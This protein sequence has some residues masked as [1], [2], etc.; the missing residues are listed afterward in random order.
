MKFSKKI[1]AQT[2]A[3]FCAALTLAFLSGPLIGARAVVITEDK[4]VSEARQ[5]AFELKAARET[6][7]EASGRVY[8]GFSGFLPKVTLA[9]NYTKLSAPQINISG[10]AA[11]LFAGNF[12][13]AMTATDLYTGQLNVSQPLFAWGRIYHADRQARLGYKMA[14]EKYRRVSNETVYKARELFYGTLLAQKMLAIAEESEK[15]AEGRYNMTKRLYDEGKASTY[16]VSRAK[17]GLENVRVAVVRASN[18]AGMSIEALKTFLNLPDDIVVEGAFAHVEKELSLDDLTARAMSSRPEVAEAAFRERAAE[19]IVAMAV[20]GD[21]PFVAATYAWTAQSADYAAPYEKWDTRWQAGV[22]LQ[23]P[24]FDGLATFGR[25]K[26]ARAGLKSLAVARQSVEAGVKLEVRSTYLNLRHIKESIRA[27]EQNVESARENL[28]I[29]QKRYSLGLM[30]YI[31]LQD[32]H[33]A[34][35]QA[36]TNYQQSLYEYNLALAAIE[37][38]TGADKYRQ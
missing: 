18:A 10:P 34:F 13:P 33:L 37:K 30:S 11:A 29:A 25:V 9:A 23:W 16:D 4:A 14:L 36:E 22:A 1:S 17:V 7:N 26:Q 8:E 28:E 2:L 21:K 27:Q 31:E 15:L 6:L 20:S 19:S 38:I 12:S 35:S 5:R 24:V 3:V 32:V